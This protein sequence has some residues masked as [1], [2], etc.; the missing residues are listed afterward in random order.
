MRSCIA[1][2]ATDDGA[3]FTSKHFGDALFYD[4]Y[5]VDGTCAEFLRRIPN[6]S[7]E[8]ED[9]HADPKKAGSIAQLL[10]SEGVQTVVSKVFGPNIKRIR[11]KFVCVSVKDMNVSE[12]IE[13]ITTHHEEILD[14][15]DAGEE[16]PVLSYRR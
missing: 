5:A 10:R 11:K 9:V 4:L 1:A 12:S 6:T 2:V 3:E 7:E 16:R 15:W 8:E 14:A 13:T